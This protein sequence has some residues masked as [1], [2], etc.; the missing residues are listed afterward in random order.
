MSATDSWRIEYE[1]S[2]LTAERLGKDPLIAFRRWLAE[3]GEAGLAEPNGMNLATVGAEGR[4][5]V[6]TVL[7]KGMD[8]RGFI[9]FT[10]Y[11][12]RKGR[13]MA[14]RPQVALNF[15]WQPLM[16]QV[17][18]EGRA[19]RLA[20]AESDAYFASR[21]RGSQLGAW[22]SPQSEEIGGRAVLTE[23]LAAVTARYEGVAVPRPPYWGG[24]LVVPDR[25]EFWQGRP[26]RLHDR[27]LFRRVEG[28]WER[29]RLAP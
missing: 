11:E 23:R 3:A 28:G 4:L 6:R 29:V 22:A 2:E 17:R 13:D 12:S 9:F 16:R 20:A 1:Q 8:E 26:S 19:E 10:N 24:Y 14:A 15:W 18:I 25:I 27:F 7:L 5:S 21:P